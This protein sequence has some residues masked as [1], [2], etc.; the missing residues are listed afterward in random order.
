[1]LEPFPIGEWTIP[2]EVAINVDAY[3]VHHDPDVYPQP[4]VFRPERFLEEP[5][6]GYSF[7]PFGGGSA[8]L[9]RC[10]ARAAGDQDRPA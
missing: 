6:D 8:P 1:M 4:H 2:P 9:P 7:L 10:S 5:P 3:G